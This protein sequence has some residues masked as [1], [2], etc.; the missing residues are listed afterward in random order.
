MYSLGCTQVCLHHG[1]IIH[2]GWVKACVSILWM[3]LPLGLLQVEGLKTL[4][5]H[6]CLLRIAWTTASWNTSKCP[7]VSPRLLLGEGATWG[8]VLHILCILHQLLEAWC[9]SYSLYH[10]G[11]GSMSNTNNAT[12]CVWL[13]W[14]RY[15]NYISLYLRIYLYT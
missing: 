10:H 8:L 4:Q 7:L 1:R 2:M 3:A 13:D 12:Q 6:L 5:N 9:V 14:T 15:R 11:R